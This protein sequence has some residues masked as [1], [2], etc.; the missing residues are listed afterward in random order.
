MFVNNRRFAAV[1]MI[2]LENRVGCTN[3]LLLANSHANFVQSSDILNQRCLLHLRQPVIYWL[4]ACST[5]YVLEPS[6]DALT[7]SSMR[8]GYDSDNDVLPSVPPFANLCSSPLH[9]LIHIH[10]RKFHTVVE[11]F[12]K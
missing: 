5:L 10:I 7:V 4:F 11:I 8:T 1:Y 12:T 9:K 3:K 6:T 2:L